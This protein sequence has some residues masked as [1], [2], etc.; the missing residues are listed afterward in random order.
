MKT[1]CRLEDFEAGPHV[2]LYIFADDLQVDIGDEKT[3][4]GDSDSPHMI[5]MDCDKSNCILHTNVEEPDDWRGWKYI[6]TEDGGWEEF[7]GWQKLAAQI[8]AAEA[9]TKVK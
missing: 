2:S 6:Y 4:I 1:I 7:S 3:V 8:A 5:I 9:N